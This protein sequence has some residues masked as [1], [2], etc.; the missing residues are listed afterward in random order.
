[1][2]PE[3][4]GWTAGIEAKTIR[5]KILQGTIGVATSLVLRSASGQTRRVRKAE[6]PSSL[7]Q[8]AA[9]ARN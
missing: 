6:L 3:R 7:S 4:L 1:M 2:A 5:R 9:A 8:F